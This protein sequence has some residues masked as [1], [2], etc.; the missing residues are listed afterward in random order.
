MYD[1]CGKT[2]DGL[3]KRYV[4]WKY[5]VYGIGNTLGL[6]KEYVDI[7]ERDSILVHGYVRQ[8]V[9]GED[10]GEYNLY[11]PTQLIDLIADR[12]YH[13]AEYHIDDPKLHKFACS[14]SK[15]DDGGQGLHGL[16]AKR[17]LSDHD[18]K[19]GVKKLFEHEK[20]QKLW[21]R[22]M[23]EEMQHRQRME[24]RRSESVHNGRNGGNGSG[25]G[26]GAGGGAGGVGGTNGFSSGAVTTWPDSGY[27]SSTINNR[28]NCYYFGY[29]IPPM[30][31]VM[32]NGSMI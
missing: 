6:C 32:I 31:M 16:D 15:V 30:F 7:M 1:F 9:E 23:F 5:D 20:F 28:F 21:K 17:F 3:L 18:T 26:G 27:S 19:R 29:D 13:E 14:L 10:S 24:K 12:F 4:L 8:F 22:R 2:F 25:I 11:V